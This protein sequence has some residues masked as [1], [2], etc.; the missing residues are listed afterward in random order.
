MA[1]VLDEE[2]VAK[3]L[4]ELP[5][6]LAEILAPLGELLDEDESARDVAIHDRVAE[7]E[8]RVLLDGGAE[9]EHVLHRDL[10]PRGGGELVERGDRVAE[11]AARA[12]RDEREGRVRRVDPLALADR[13][14]HGHDLLQAGPLEDERLAARPHRLDHLREL[15]RAE[16]EDEVRRRLLDQLQQRIP[17]GRRQLVGLVDDVDLVPTLCGLQHRALA[18][19]ADLVDPAL[20]GGVHLD[21]V[22]GRPRGDRPRDGVVGSKSAFG[23]PSAFSAF[24]RILAIDVFPVPRGP[25]NRYA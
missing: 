9:L 15:G 25:A 21:D 11:R 4:Q 24:A 5:G 10:L 3:M 13:A 1:H 8:Q 16:D 17:R 6:Q 19:L 12:A 18:D 22:E 23:P 2:Q 14:K 20:R 7:T